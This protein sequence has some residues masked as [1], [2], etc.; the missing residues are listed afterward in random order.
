MRFVLARA[1]ALVHDCDCAVLAIARSGRKK[2]GSEIAVKRLSKSSMQ[3]ISEF[4]N[5]IMLIGKLQHR[6]LKAEAFP[7]IEYALGINPELIFY[8]EE[9]VGVAFLR[10]TGTYLG[11]ERS[12][13]KRK[14]PTRKV[15]NLFGNRASG[16]PN[17]RGLDAKTLLYPEK[18]M[19][20]NQ[21]LSQAIDLVKLHKVEEMTANGGTSAQTSSKNVGDEKVNVT[22]VLLL[23]AAVK[24]I[25]RD[26]YYLCSVP[27]S[28]ANQV[29]VSFL[30]VTPS[31][32][33]DVSIPSFAN[34]RCRR[35]SPSWVPT[36]SPET[37][38]ARFHLP[39]PCHC[40]RSRSLSMGLCLLSLELLSEPFQSFL[41]AMNLHHTACNH[42]LLSP[43]NSA[44]T[45]LA[46]TSL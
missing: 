35:R 25:E 22:L 1:E 12:P 7:R 44:A 32:L 8:T 15:V 20:L 23:Q 29:S 27:S 13:S 39:S 26:L 10:L 17:V 14:E 9:E 19:H 34:Q 5:E 38:A 4:K 40:R 21:S 31:R 37:P 24:R 3:G 11:D 43:W 28:I 16:E 2:D 36:T 45:F 18:Y 6:N 42:P 41:P 33:L 46:E 30:P